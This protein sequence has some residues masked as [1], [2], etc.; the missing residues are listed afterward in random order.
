MKV[1]AEIWKETDCEIKLSIDHGL[2]RFALGQRDY[3]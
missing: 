1:G 3:F 2:L